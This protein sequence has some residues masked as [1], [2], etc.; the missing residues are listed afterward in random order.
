M[1]KVIYSVNVGGYDKLRPPPAA[2]GWDCVLFTDRPLPW[3]A[4]IFNRRRWRVVV[5]DLQNLPR[6]TASRRPKLLPH[7]Y[8]KD[9]DY[10]L[11]V[12]GSI[13]FHDD[14]TR[15][16]DIMNWPNFGA[17]IHPYRA[18][19]YDEAEECIRQGKAPAE[20]LRA[21]MSAYREAGLPE[22]APLYE[23]GVLL[24]RH[25]DPEVIALDE[26]WWDEFERFPHRDQ[27]SLPFASWRTGIVPQAAV[28]EVKRRFF[29]ARS[30]D[31]SF[32][33]RFR[34]SVK[35]RLGRA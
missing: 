10:S 30:H 24:R 22:D 26:A 32:W 4:Q 27:I 16:G 9:W 33:R 31:R 34:R 23:N 5:L 19:P 17:A 14:A 28:Q 12:D 21:Q 3:H 7:L 18:N 25:H 20:I 1:R 11:Y 2:P 29:S 35:K 8:L 6:A 15:W 13:V